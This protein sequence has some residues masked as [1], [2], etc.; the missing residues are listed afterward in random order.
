MFD[1]QMG[2]WEAMK[3]SYDATRGYKWRIIAVWTVCGFL[4]LLTLG[5]GALVTTPLATMAMASLYYRVQ[6]KSLPEKYARTRPA[7]YLIALIP[8]VI[9]I[10]IMGAIVIYLVQGGG[11]ERLR[12]ALQN[13]PQKLP[14]TP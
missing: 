4:G 12:E 1:N 10:G 7:E 8:F 3:A 14:S 13:L 2:P 6:T 9:V 11:L 5:I